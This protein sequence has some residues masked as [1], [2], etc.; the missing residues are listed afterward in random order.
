MR[1]IATQS[2][3]ASNF[4]ANNTAARRLR[5]AGNFG[6]K[7]KTVQLLWPCYGLAMPLLWP[8]IFLLWPCYGSAMALLW[9][10]MAFLC[11][12]YGLAMAMLWLR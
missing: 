3:H 6:A 11:P 5:D 1:N 2:A 7:M 12:C 10:A 9:L 4:G 8:C